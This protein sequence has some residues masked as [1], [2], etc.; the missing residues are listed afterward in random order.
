MRG[1]AGEEGWDEGWH[2]KHSKR[3]MRPPLSSSHALAVS[4]SG[5]PVRGA[6]GRGDGKLT[7]DA[8]RHQGYRGCTKAAAAAN[9]PKAAVDAAFKGPER[10]GFE[11]HVLRAPPKGPAQRPAVHAPAVHAPAVHAP[12]VHAP[13]VHAPAKCLNR[14]C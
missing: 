3:A 11:P 13:A 9:A 1:A 10:A 2:Y 12:A 7:V 4:A 6:T 14:T 8:P 5:R